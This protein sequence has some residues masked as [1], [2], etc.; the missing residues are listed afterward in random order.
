MKNFLLFS[1]ILICTTWSLAQISVEEHQKIETAVPKKPFVQPVK[2]RKLLVI[3]LHM[4]DGQIINGHNSIPYSNLALDLMGKA[5]GAFEP[6]FSNDTLMFTAEN[7]EQFDA[8]CFNNTAG[9][10]FKSPK[11]RANLLNFVSQGK[12]F[13]GIH[14]AGATFVQWPKYDQWPAFGEML[15]GYENGGHPWKPYEWIT[16]RVEE[17]DHPLTS[18]FKDKF[19]PVSDEVFQF[20]EPYSRDK[21]RVLLVIDPDKTDMNES[22]RILP[23]RLADKDLAISWIHEYGKGRVFYSCLGHNAHIF[24]DPVILEHF[25]AGIQ[26][27][28][29]DLPASATP[30]N[31]VIRK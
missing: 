27:A 8:I 12:G 11:L 9:V 25:L 29:G 1:L 13:V 19:F 28:L 17:P 18:M 3:N 6:V 21:L 20:Q 16:L 31:L 22:R 10:L 5:T 23:Q 24:W 26:Y 14:A 15:G 7:L 2:P 30:S 4:R